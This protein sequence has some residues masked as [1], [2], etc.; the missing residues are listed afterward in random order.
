[1]SRVSSNRTL[2]FHNF[3]QKKEACAASFSEMFRV[4]LP[5]LPFSSLI[6]LQA[7]RIF[8][9]QKNR[10]AMEKAKKMTLTT[11]SGFVTTVIATKAVMPQKRAGNFCFQSFTLAMLGMYFPNRFL[12]CFTKI[13]KRA[14]A[15]PISMKG[16]MAPARLAMIWVLNRTQ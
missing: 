2:D 9:T 7:L 11:I 16:M 12:T 14:I 3:I 13:A 1:M 6:A 15:T 10:T 4:Y 5:D 8:S